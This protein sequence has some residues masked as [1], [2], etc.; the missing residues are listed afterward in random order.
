M[1]SQGVL[2]QVQDDEGARAGRP[3]AFFRAMRT[4]ISESPGCRKACWIE[5]FARVR[6]AVRRRRAAPRKV[7]PDRLGPALRRGTERAGNTPRSCRAKSGHRI[8]S[9]APPR[10]SQDQAIAPVTRKLPPRRR[11]RR[12]PRPPSPAQRTPPAVPASCWR[13]PARY[14]R[15]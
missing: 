3:F 12:Q 9:G 2:K 10:L 8:S 7:L 1:Q 13:S 11:L 6:K 5:K 14:P 4:G 15:R